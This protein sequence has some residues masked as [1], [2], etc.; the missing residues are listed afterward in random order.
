MRCGVISTNL[1]ENIKFHIIFVKDVCKESNE[2]IFASKREE[3][4]EGCMKL[5]NKTVYKI[6]VEFSSE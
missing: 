2:I 1:L 4:T 6:S 5:H 3:M